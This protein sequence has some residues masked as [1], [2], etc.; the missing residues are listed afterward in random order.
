MPIDIQQ[1]KAI[2]TLLCSATTEVLWQGAHELV[3]VPLDPHRLRCRVGSG[4]A[5]YYRRLGRH[6][7]LINYGCRMVASKT[8]PEVAALWLTGREILRRNYF[9]GELSFPGLLAHTCCHEFG[10]FL[11]SISGGLGRGSIHNQA[12]YRIVDRIHAAG[13]AQE[14]RAYIE[15][16]AS[17]LGLPLAFGPQSTPRPRPDAFEPGELV[18]FEYRGSPVMGEVLRVNRKTVNVRPLRPVLAADYFRISPQFLA[19]HQKG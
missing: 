15:Q 9:A 5:T 10:H 8:D 17:L 18:S 19:R 7:H 11:Q 1:C 2:A 4:E 13:L 3:A 6:Q 12:F 16:H 14:L